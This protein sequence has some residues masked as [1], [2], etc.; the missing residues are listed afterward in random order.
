[1]KRL[2]CIAIFVFLFSLPVFAADFPISAGEY[3]S[4]TRTVSMRWDSGMGS[5]QGWI[6]PVLIN[7]NARVTDLDVSVLFAGTSNDAVVVSSYVSN[8]GAYLYLWTDDNITSA[9]TCSVTLD[10]S[11]KAIYNL[12]SDPLAINFG[13][14]SQVGS[15]GYSDRVLLD[16]LDQILKSVSSDTIYSDFLGEDALV[17]FDDRYFS[18]AWISGSPRSSVDGYYTLKFIYYFLYCFKHMSHRFS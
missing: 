8:G 9:F 7:T 16:I 4:V 13:T 10:V 12:D 1:M 5:N 2:L 14:P 3:G 6:V 15:G 18:D 11:F 17:Y